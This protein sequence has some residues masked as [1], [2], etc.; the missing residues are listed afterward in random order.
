MFK[1]PI[2]VLEIFKHPSAVYE[3]FLNLFSF[4]I[5]TVYSLKGLYHRT[6][7]FDVEKSFLKVYSCI[8]EVLH[9]YSEFDPFIKK[10]PGGLLIKIVRYL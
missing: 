7:A 5:F 3:N 9:F 6:K 8:L 10:T 1:K 4:L 2:K